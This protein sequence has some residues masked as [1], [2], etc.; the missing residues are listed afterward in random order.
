MV[1][2]FLP[3]SL[4]FYVFLKSWFVSKL[5]LI[6]LLLKEKGIQVRPLNLPP[7]GICNFKTERIRTERER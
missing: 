6:F 5:D 3:T 7:D 1:D 2:P 4:E